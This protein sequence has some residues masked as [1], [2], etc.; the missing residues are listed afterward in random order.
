M[1]YPQICI[2][3]I[4]GHRFER[5]KTEQQ[6]RLQHNQQGTERHGEDGREKTLPLMPQRRRR[7]DHS[8]CPRW[9]FGLVDCS[10][11]WEEIPKGSYPVERL[12]QVG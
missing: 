2:S 4:D 10:R 12:R 5:E 11:P 1:A 3:L 8:A 9:R 7:M 6:A